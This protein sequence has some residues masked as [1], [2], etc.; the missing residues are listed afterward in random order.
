M[1]VERIPA[2]DRLKR[3]LQFERARGCADT[4]VIGGIDALLRNLLSPASG[5]PAPAVHTAVK[6]LGKRAYASLSAEARR[7]WIDAVLSLAPVPAPPSA[8]VP[9]HT[10]PLHTDRAARAEPPAPPRA[11]VEAPGK[12]PKVARPRLPA[13]AGTSPG[14]TDATPPSLDSPVT[15]LPGVGS[16]RA[17]LFGK[18]RIGTIRDLLYHFPHRYDDY[19]RVVPISA[20]QVGEQRTVVAR[21]WSSTAVVIGRTVRKST[22]LI[23]GDETGNMQVVFFNNPYP[24]QKLRTNQRVTLSGTVS[25]FQGQRQ[26]QNPEWEII[27]E[28]SD[29]DQAIHTGRLVPVYPLT[30]GI[31]NRAMRQ[32]VRAAL[33]RVLDQLP[34]PLPADV[35]EKHGFPDVRSAIRQAHYPDNAAT[36]EAARRRL[37]YDELLILQL[38]VL[39]RRTRRVSTLRA[40]ALMLPADL[41]DAFVASL[42]FP[43]TGAQRRSVDVILNDIASTTPMARLLQGDV[44]SGKTVVAAAALLA[45]AASGCQSVIMAP[46]EILAE[47]H[48]RTLCRAFGADAPEGSHIARCD[49]AWFGKP[50]RLAL[51]R[52]GLRAKAKREVQESIALGLIDVAVGTQALIQGG[53]SFDRLGLSVIDEQHRFGVEQRTTLSGKGENAHLLVM[54]ATPIPRTLALSI[55]GDLDISLIDEMPAG[56]LPV[57]TRIVEPHERDFAYRFVRDQVESGFQAFVICPLVEESESIEARAATE[58][59][60]RLRS[61]IFPDLSVSLLHGRMSPSAKDAVMQGFRERTADVLV[62]TAVVEVG[63]DI[64]NATVI[65]IEGADRFGLAQLHQFRGRVGRSGEQSFCLLLSD[66]SSPEVRT[67][68]KLLEDTSDGLELAEADLRLRGPGDY[69]GTRQSGLPTLRQARL[70]DVDILESAREDAGALLLEDPDLASPALAEVRRRVEQLATTAGEAN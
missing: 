25:S 47:Q 45:A 31:Q 2:S 15:R 7:A 21:V 65:M 35:R 60:E 13:A 19:S 69:F 11:A 55:Y 9:Q 28:G 32:F 20:L 17:E 59:Y 30:Q 23:V 3:I 44:G 66:S 36:L 33:D 14:K 43:L 57:K 42:P 18:L 50:L 26:M 4:A 37:A 41:R 49:P 51:L 27:E 34:D 68:L 46:T 58:E 38:S 22:E 5:P 64:S 16:N 6:L 24:A 53:V 1:A 48:F 70:S 12:L 61:E 52:G 8:T 62:S 39:A 40:P 10:L 54:T 67:R 29:I 56:R 63:I